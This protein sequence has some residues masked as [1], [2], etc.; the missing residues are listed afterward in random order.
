MWRPKNSEHSSRYNFSARSNLLRFIPTSLKPVEKLLLAC[1]MCR[2]GAKVSKRVYS[3]TKD[4][5]RC[6]RPISATD[7]RHVQQVEELLTDN[8]RR[9]REELNEKLSIGSIVFKTIRSLREECIGREI[10][11]KTRTQFTAAEVPSSMARAQLVPGP[12]TR[13]TRGAR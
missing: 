9:T 6:R 4:A 12:R 8:N 3:D 5:V 1:G 7:F 11:N 10:R 13:L 2:N